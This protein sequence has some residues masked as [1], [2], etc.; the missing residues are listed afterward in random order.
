MGGERKE[1]NTARSRPPSSLHL[2]ATKA[3]DIHRAEGDRSQ[4]H[5]EK[6]DEGFGTLRGLWGPFTRCW[7]TVLRRDLEVRPGQAAGPGRA[8][9]GRPDLR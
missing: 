6:G 1:G 5:R 2:Q 8:K 7:G 9:M 3:D 4:G